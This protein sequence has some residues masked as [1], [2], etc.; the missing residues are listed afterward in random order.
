[1]TTCRFSASNASS[2][3]CLSISASIA[4]DFVSRK[5]AMSACS[6]IGGIAMVRFRSSSG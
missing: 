2:R 4:A 6:L 3:S 1:M 5:S